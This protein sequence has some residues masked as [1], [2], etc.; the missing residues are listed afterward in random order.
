[1]GTPSSPEFVPR[2]E[3][4]G[5]IRIVIR[6][7]AAPHGGATAHATTAPSEAA[8]EIA[9]HADQRRTTKDE[10]RFPPA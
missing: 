3:P 4:R 5:A 6:E 10:A 2:L 9:A 1:M 8:R 7:A